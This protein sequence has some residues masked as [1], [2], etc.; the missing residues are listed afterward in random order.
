[1]Y[2]GCLQLLR[3]TVLLLHNGYNDALPLLKQNS[4]SFYIYDMDQNIGTYCIM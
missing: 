3:M 2:E 1:M 4:E